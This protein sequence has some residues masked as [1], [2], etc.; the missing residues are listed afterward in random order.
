M[1]IGAKPWPSGTNKDDQDAR[2]N[3]GSRSAGSLYRNPVGPAG[4]TVMDE[5]STAEIERIMS[6]EWLP[7]STW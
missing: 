5:A 7:M 1:L 4:A 3:I 2:T 6:D